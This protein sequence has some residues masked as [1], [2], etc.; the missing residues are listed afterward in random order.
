MC[1]HIQKL[2]SL[3]C[4]KKHMAGMATQDHYAHRG[5]HMAGMATQD[6][7]AHRGA[8]MAGMATQ[9]HCTHRGAL[10]QYFLIKYNSGYD[11]IKK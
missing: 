5:A 9:D 8:H 7:Y 11:Q 6:H 1:L 2:Q 10:I 3:C 4:H